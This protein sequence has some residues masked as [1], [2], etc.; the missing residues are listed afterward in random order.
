MSDGGDAQV[1]FTGVHHTFET[2]TGSIAALSGITL[3]IGGGET[4]VAVGP[5]GCGKST[6][7]K[8]IAGLYRPTSGVVEVLPNPCN[9]RIGYIAQSVAMLPWRSALQNA[10]IGFELQMRDVGPTSTKHREILR[11]WFE[12]FGLSG[13]EN[14]AW[15]SL[16]GGMKQRVS[17]ICAMS[18]EP[19][20]LMGDEPFSAID[21]DSRL[22]LLSRFK[23][24][25][26]GTSVTSIIV[27]H[28]IEEAI[29][30]ADR[31]VVLSK[32]PGTI[33]AEIPSRIPAHD[34]DA[35][36]VRAMPEFR[37]MFQEVWHYLRDPI[38]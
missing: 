24:L 20:L 28:D 11:G 9:P 18:V 38:R 14:A 31:I 1:R 32:R 19:G 35:I 33:V 10:A 16:S 34:L 12:E 17:L 4:C 30:V 6:L 3:T 8:L 25:C 15:D 22:G 21:F 26:R 27:T 37:E 29:F 23:R 5:S 13:F 36:E 2:R 7:L